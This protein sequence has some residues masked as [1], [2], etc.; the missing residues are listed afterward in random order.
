[1]SIPMVMGLLMEIVGIGA[2][3]LTTISILSSEIIGR[4]CSGTYLDTIS[5]ASAMGGAQ[6]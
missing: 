2:L 6:L 4:L 3:I 1:M 5:L